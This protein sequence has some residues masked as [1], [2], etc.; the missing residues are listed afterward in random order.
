MKLVFDDPDFDGQ[1]QRSVSKDNFGMANAGECLAIAAKISTSD[2]SSWYAAFAGFAKTLQG[3]AE[4]AGDSG[5]RASARESYLRACEY[6]R[7]A[8]FYERADL[9]NP[10]LHIAYAAHRACFRAALPLLE[11]PIDVVEVP[12]AE[13]TLSGYF[14][15]PDDTGRPRPTVIMPGGYDGTAEELYPTIVAG[16]ARGYNVFCFDGPGQGAVLYEQRIFMRPD[17]EAVL[18][19]VVDLIAARADVDADKLIL[20]GRSFGGYLA[21]RAAS[22]EHRFAALVVDPGQYDLGAGIDKRLPGHLLRQLDDDLPAADA[23]FEN[24]LAEEKYR[25]MFL[26]RMATHGATTVR[27]YLKMMQAYTNAGYAERITCP[28][29]VCDNETDRVSTMQGQL[30]YDRLICAKTF[31]V[32]NAAEGAEGHCQG[33]GQT[34]FFAR[35]FDWA[36]ETL[37]LTARFDS[38][39]Q[40]NPPQRT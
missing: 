36:D 15:R 31:V 1:L 21:P 5:H 26:P 11:F 17:W 12:F 22:Q 23:P 28:T 37:G 16:V 19:P 33:L 38:I 40:N 13:A 39:D 9:D 34:I 7:N 20:L 35:M 29:L 2:A 30:L 25:R 24:L 27:Q 18:P 32:F 8:F 4:R 3:I 10:K 6:Y 14:G